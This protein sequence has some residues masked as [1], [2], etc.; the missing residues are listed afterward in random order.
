MKQL[1]SI[2]SILFLT[3]SVVS[4][5]QNFS[6]IKK[7]EKQEEI[8][9]NN[10]FENL[11]EEVLLDI[12]EY[13]ISNNQYLKSVS[14][15]KTL[16][17]VCKLFNNM[18]QDARIQKLLKEKKQK[19]DLSNSILD[20]ELD[21]HDQ[22]DWKKIKDLILNGA[23]INLINKNYWT[24]L[25]CAARYGSLDEVKFVIDN[26]F[27]LNHK[28]VSR[29]IANSIYFCEDL[30]VVKYL[31]NQGIDVNIQNEYGEP[32][33]LCA[34]DKKL[35]DIVALLISKDANINIRSK[36]NDCT[37]LIYA[38]YRNSLEIVQ[39]LIE[40]KADLNLLS[41]NNKTALDLAITDNNQAIIELLSKHGAKRA[42]QL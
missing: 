13:S 40:N 10:Y 4:M 3:N 39:L 12:I 32:A 26:G 28:Y 41:R 36:E 33:L 27:D 34:A 14:N 42:N 38:T 17:L 21:R 23:N 31:I 30:E 20:R 2:F 29:A 16:N 24:T 8:L 25:T 37:A 11:P 35:F 18:C 5:E 15:S 6:D 19:Y 22:I 1:I 7:E 9:G